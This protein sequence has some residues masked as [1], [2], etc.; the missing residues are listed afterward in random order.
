MATEVFQFTGVAGTTHYLAIFNTSGQVLDFADNTFKALSGATTPRVTATERTD[1]GGAKSGFTASVDLANVNSGT[2]PTKYFADWYT[3]TGLTTC[4]SNTT[5]FCVASSALVVLGGRVASVIGD[6]GGNVS[7]NV[8]GNVAGSVASVTAGVTL[9]TSQPNYAPSKAGDAMTLTSG[10]R[11]SIANEVEAQIIDDTDT[12]KVLLAITNKIAAAN[13][14]LSGL[15]LAAIAA[16]VRTEL[17]VELARIDA[18]VST[19]LAASSYTA[20]TTPPTA[21]AI[22]SEIDT[23]ST[24]LAAIL[25]DTG[26]TLPAT[27]F[28]ANVSKIAG[29]ELSATHLANAASVLAAR[30]YYALRAQVQTNASNTTSRFEVTTSDPASA[31]L[32][33]VLHF[34]GTG[35][36]VSGEM[37]ICTLV[38]SSLISGNRIITVSPALSEVPATG[39]EF[40][41]ESVAPAIAGDAMTLADGAITADKIVANAITN[42]KVADDLTVGSVTGSVGSVTGNVGGSVA[43]VTAGVTLD[44]SLDVYHA[45][46]HFDVD[47]ATETDEYTVTWFKNAVRVTSGITV[48]TLQLVKRADGS[49]LLAATAMTQVGSTGSYKKDCTTT[50]RLTAGEAVIAVVVATIDGSSRSFSKVIGRDSE[51][52]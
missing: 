22:R 2:T 16:Q 37:S 49:N 21:A 38:E 25:E 45:D 15:T 39:A 36:G 17:A 11:T 43:S 4:V 12:E 50:N 46:I 1:M 18:A 6:V 32:G 29:S 23:N 7:G 41:V 48:P 13:P 44:S 8:G 40:V 14:D 35:A 5:E 26:T 47:E 10:E 52:A 20:P 33:K 42:A 34:F 51:A 31:I 30:N 28:A 3:D 24:K 9:A 19:R 27:E